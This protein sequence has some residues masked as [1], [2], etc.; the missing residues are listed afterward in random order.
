MLSEVPELKLTWCIL[1]FRSLVW[2]KSKRIYKVN[3]DKY[4]SDYLL[5]GITCVWYCNCQYSVYDGK[6]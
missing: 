2:V 3:I 4:R 5:F 6:I 1:M